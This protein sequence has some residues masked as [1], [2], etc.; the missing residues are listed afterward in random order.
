MKSFR[1]FNRR[2]NYVSFVVTIGTMM[3][4]TA[5]AA[6]SPQPSYQMAVYEDTA[7]GDLVADGRYALAIKKIVARHKSPMSFV[8]KSNLCVAYAMSGDYVNAEL[9][10]DAAITYAEKT[11]N[12]LRP[13]ERNWASFRRSAVNEYMA[14]ALSNRGVLHV[15]MGEYDLARERLE[16]AVALHPAL[17]TPKQNLAHLEETRPTAVADNVQEDR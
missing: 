4:C 3:T 13:R 2:M 6:G 5:A 1:K 7:Y 10:C 12:T 17:A 16:M 11:T 15:A 14:I 9:I 8:P